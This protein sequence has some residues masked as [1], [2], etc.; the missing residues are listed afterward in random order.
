M[1]IA[2]AAIAFWHHF[3]PWATKN[4]DLET[5]SH[6]ATPNRRISQKCPQSES[7]EAP[8]LHPKIRRPSVERHSEPLKGDRVYPIPLPP[9]PA[10]ALPSQMIKTPV[11]HIQ[12]AEYAI[13]HVLLHCR[14]PPLGPTLGICGWTLVF[15]RCPPRFLA[16]GPERW[17]GFGV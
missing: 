10:E 17:L 4:M 5:I 13:L 7:R 8:Q 14:G 2:H 16:G 15:E 1:V 9:F 11:K 6:F 12:N 3:Y